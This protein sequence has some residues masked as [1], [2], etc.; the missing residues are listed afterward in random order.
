MQLKNLFFFKDD[1]ERTFKVK[2]SI[3]ISLFLKCGSV[4]IT[5][6]LVPIT[7]NY[8]NPE[9][10]GVW[11]TISSMIYWITVFDIGI[12]NGLKNE[13]AYAIATKDESNL[14]KY[15][16]TS[17]AILTLIAI[18]IFITFYILTL[19]FNWNHILN[20]SNRNNLNIRPILI[21]FIGFFS[22]QFILQLLDAV[23]AAVQKTYLSAIILFLGQLAGLVGIYLL[24]LFVPGSLFLLVTIMAGSPIL[25]IIIATVYL[26]N[27]S[28]SRFAPS[29]KDIDFRFLK[30]LL[31]VG[32]NFFLIQICAMILIYTDNFIITQILGPA[33]VTTYYIPFKLFSVISM[34]FVIV[35][36]PYWSAFTDA[37]TTNDYIW[38]KANI[39][40]LRLIWLALSL[41]AIIIFIFSKFLYRVW[42]HN[43]VDVPISISFCMLIYVIVFTWQTLHVYFLNG[44][45]KIK[46]QLVVVICGVFVNIPLSIYFG[47]KFGLPGIINANT[48][49][50][51]LIGGICTIQYN[52]I[53]NKTAKGIWNQ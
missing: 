30:K 9:Q 8:I 37:Y 20:I 49:V 2:K 27:T 35:I 14:K 44:I 33:A 29:I 25:I 36:T 6:L 7:I 26:Y 40:R 22:I 10:Y 13:I 38:I 18:F 52:K 50:F 4:L 17:Y 48:I 19:F 45:G 16:S 11:L 12:G 39:K 15:V 47:E 43:S 28:L 46:L 23:I 31:S 1:H 3:I 34:L 51:F 21:L 53:V 41:M 42:I 5:F 32:G 24:T